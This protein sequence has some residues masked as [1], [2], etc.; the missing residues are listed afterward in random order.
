MAASAHMTQCSRCCV[1]LPAARGLV[2][3]AKVEV[4]QLDLGDL[5][6]VRD[7]ASRALDKGFPLD[8]LVNNAGALL[9]APLNCVWLGDKGLHIRA[10]P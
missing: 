8:V 10:R 7:F 2:P 5:A 3:G 6:T 4:A 1:M 9:A